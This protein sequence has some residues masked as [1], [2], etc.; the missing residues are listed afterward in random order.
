M[1]QEHTQHIEITHHRFSPSSLKM[2][3]VCPG[4]HQDNSGDTEAADEGTLLHAAVETGNL[5]GLTDEQVA[6]VMQC[7]EVLDAESIGYPTRHLEVKLSILDGYTFGTADVVLI[8]A[9]GRKAKILDWK[10]GYHAVDRAVSN[11]QSRSYALGVL[12]MFPT[13]EDVEALFFSPRINDKHRGAFSR[14]QDRRFLEAA[15]RAV[16]EKANDHTEADLYPTEMV[17]QYCKVRG[18]CS[19]LTSR[20]LV[21]A[22]RYAPLEVLDDEIHSSDVTDPTYMAKMYAVA[23]VAEKWAGSVKAHARE[24]VMGGQPIPGYAL[25]ERR[26]VRKIVNPLAAFQAVAD[27]VVDLDPKALIAEC[28][29]PA[30]ALEKIVSEGLDKNERAEA[31]AKLNQALSDAEAIEEGAPIVYLQK[32]KS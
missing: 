12:E 3:A 17:C 1:E 27:L 2:R 10:F 4:F 16:I 15:I 8:S 6:L 24:M 32:S 26:G 30:A 5:N 29:I 11:F 21:I 9:D 13:V 23:S 25:R 28:T 20:N 22:K 31:I 18:T 19:A 7:I 14:M